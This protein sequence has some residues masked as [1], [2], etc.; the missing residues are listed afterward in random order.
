MSKSLNI[1]IIDDSEDDI[2]FYTRVIKKQ[3]KENKVKAFFDAKAAIEYMKQAF[4]DCILLDYSLP[5]QDG[6]QIL[7]QIKLNQIESPILMLSGEISQQIA[8]EALEN[9]AVDYLQKAKMFQGDNLYQA[10]LACVD[11]KKN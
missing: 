8:A 9:G 4:I 5:G 7:K 2:M 10:I 6:I 3:H 11:L 1:L